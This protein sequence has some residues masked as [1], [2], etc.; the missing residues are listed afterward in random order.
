MSYQENTTSP[1]EISWQEK[2]DS[3]PKVKS[4]RSISRDKLVVRQ[5]VETV[6]L[7]VT[8]VSKILDATPDHLDKSVLEEQLG[9]ISHFF[10]TA[11][12]TSV[13]LPV[14]KILAERDPGSWD[15]ASMVPES[16]ENLRASR[17]ALVDDR[18]EEGPV[19]EREK[20]LL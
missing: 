20:A 9:I 8:A 11:K 10:R 17:K 3:A 16:F 15:K 12:Y 6:Q 14:L 2:R 19:M 7:A 1:D 13:M 18:Y 4:I 5:T